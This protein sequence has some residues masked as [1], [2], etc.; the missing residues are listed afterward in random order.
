QYL[1]RTSEA[2]QEYQLSY[3]RDGET[4]ETTVTPAAADTV[5]ARLGRDRPNLDAEPEASPAK[6]P[7]DQTEVEGFG[8]S[9]SPLTPALAE[10][11]QWSE[12]AAGVVVTEVDPEGPAAAAGME[13]GDLITRTIRDRAIT[14]V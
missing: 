12:V 2:G 1:V 10:Q 9:V 7:I 3:L 4:H 6:P 11:F 5:A 8:F 13:V 14:S